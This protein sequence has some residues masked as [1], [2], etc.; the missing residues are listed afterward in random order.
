MEIIWERSFLMQNMSKFWQMSRPF[1]LKR[2]TGV[3]VR[4]VR[5]L[6]NRWLHE[7][8]GGLV[9]NFDVEFGPGRVQ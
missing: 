8:D 4:L 9:T 1:F 3:R 2:I 7:K 5:G 6:E